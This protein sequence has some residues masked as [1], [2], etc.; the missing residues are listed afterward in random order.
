MPVTERSTPSSDHAPRETWLAPEQ[1]GEP[2]LRLRYE[3]EWVTASFALT[4]A[5]VA[6]RKEATEQWLAGWPVL[7]AGQGLDVVYQVAA[8]RLECVL[9]GHG[10]ADDAAAAVVDARALWRNLDIG[11][12]RGLGDYHFVPSDDPARLESAVPFWR[13][14]LRPLRLRIATRPSFG[15]LAP[16][17]PE[18]L[19][20]RVAHPPLRPTSHF[21]ALIDAL[22]WGG[23]L[24]IQLQARPCQLTRPQEAL[25]RAALRDLD[26]TGRVQHVP[27]DRPLAMT[28]ELLAAL[29]R[30][31]EI[32]GQYPFG[33]RMQCVVSADKPVPEALLALL[34]G[35]LFHG[36][37]VTWSRLAP[38][39]G[40]DE[41]ELDLGDAVP[42]GGLLPPL[43]PEPRRLLDRGLPV[44]Y[45][46]APALLPAEGVLLGQVGTGRQP[47]PVRF[48]PADRTRHCYI[49]GATGTGKSTLLY[50]LLV[51]D[52]EAGAGVCL[53]DPHG[54]LHRQVLAAVP[55][56][57]LKDVIL[58]EPGDAERAVGINFLECAGPHPQVRMNF[59]TNELI[60]IFHR[61]YDLSITGG[62]IFEQYM[63]N[64][65]L[66]VMD[67]EIAGGTLMDVPLLFED[68]RYREQLLDH[69]R[70]PYTVS[71]W[72]RQAEPAGGDASLKNMA[73]Y[74]TSKL[75]QF[76]S[77]ALLRPI[78]GQSRSTVDF[79]ACL[80]QGRIVLVDLP[81]GVLGQL[82]TQ[83]LGML[84]IGKLFD[85][86]LQRTTVPE[87][88]RRPFFLYVDEAH[89]FTTETVAH[90]LAEARK[91]GLYLTLAN[92][93]LTQMSGGL[94]DAI[95]GNV[96]SLLLFR[97]GVP[98]AERMAP[99]VKPELRVRDLEDL[100]DRHV[101]ARLLLLG[102]P[103]RPFVFSTL[104]PRPVRALDPAAQA[105]AQAELERSRLHY[106]RPVAEVEQ[107]LLRRRQGVRR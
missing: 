62:P 7:G 59:I 46:D 27:A 67:N 55:P 6:R 16:A 64:A 88:Q 107:E 30:E 8:G 69:C 74:I 2:P 89:N 11:L 66:L 81:K 68:E 10:Q 34:G 72:R 18:R 82:D 79:R 24:E 84:I 85:A 49:L 52:I 92:Q 40:P 23:A 45:G 36:R 5:G 60:R 25:L 104:A 77:N 15:Y 101:A 93:N 78:I 71:F 42:A 47:R 4:L 102:A 87:G 63:R 75:N 98:D 57:R 70:N 29:R 83:L 96:G 14:V 43:L 99:Y 65:L 26:A 61:L 80:D 28:D 39:T 21:N 48:T 3:G 13:T 56:R 22:G 91:F 38:E 76:T 12:R 106:T 19:G 97:L 37:P 41:D 94:V 50:N 51:Q 44:H 58:V 90:L 54:D 53:L 33:W 103:S 1:P 32:W 86:A 105:Q 17:E 20:L 100:P 9:R 35:E 31:L 73:P 95:L